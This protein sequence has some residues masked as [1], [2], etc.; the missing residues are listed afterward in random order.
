[1]KHIL[2]TSLLAV[3]GIA[4]RA[5]Y[6]VIDT[7]LVESEIYP[8]TVHTYRV[9]VPDAYDASRPAA[10]YLGLD[11]VLC[12]AP[13][14][15]DSLTA[16]G[17]MPITIGVYLQPGYIQGDSATVLRYNRSNEFDATDGRFAEFLDSELLPAVESLTTADGR[18][19]HLTA[20][21]A[22]RMIFGLSSGG[23]AAFTAAWHRPDLF[24]K[25]YS[26]CGTFVPMRGG[27]DL[28]A[29]VR[30]H[31]PLPLRVFLQDG[32]TD[33]W[34]QIFGSWY[35]ANLQL[36]SA[37]DWAGYDCAFDWAEGGHSVLRTS[38]IFPQVM[39]WMWR[40]E[41]DS[42]VARPTAN[43]LLKP[44]LIEGED[45]RP[46]E[47]T[48]KLQSVTP[49]EAVY[50]DSS[51]VAV[52]VP[53]SNYINQYILGADGS[54]LYGQR[55]Y[56]LHTYDNAALDIPSMTFD[57]DGNLWVITRAGIQ[58]CDQNGR[59]RGI[60][61]LPLGFEVSR[62]CIEIHDGQ[63]SISDGRVAYTRRLRVKA[64]GNQRPLSQGQA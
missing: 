56:W 53:G 51:L 36:A 28:E 52:A 14:V 16:I 10:L 38:Q 54:R 5:S 55:F 26:G 29:I 33:S 15:I 8:G 59:V 2:V 49:A 45:W 44:L 47:R 32:F 58:I 30:K 40:G 35:E 60:L 39:T 50:P 12:R 42:V 24:G 23:I 22:N 6:S 43:S 61:R 27:N 46:S 17:A 34:N 48:I 62:A 21:P 1:M 20:N 18:R 25:V 64:P 31:E 63:I 41:G 11:G 9:Y 3:L 4:A 7:C 13:E 57:G 37:L 19:V